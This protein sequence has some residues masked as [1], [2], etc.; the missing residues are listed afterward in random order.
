MSKIFILFA[1]LL[2]SVGI[3]S[4]SFGHVA[5]AG[6]QLTGYIYSDDAGWISLNCSNTNSCDSIDY[7]V[8]AD[9]NGNLSGY[10]YSQNYG[11]INLSPNFG[12]VVVLADSSL[13]GYGYSAAGW[14]KIDGAKVFSINDLQNEAASAKKIIDNNNLSDVETMSL[15][16]SLCNK[17]L[18]I[19]TNA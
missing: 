1:G 13:S 5:A 17:I 11:W 10:G 8:L 16:N 3:F 18:S 4:C 2:L 15:L 6:Q 14:V 19:D 9:S 12:G 7:S